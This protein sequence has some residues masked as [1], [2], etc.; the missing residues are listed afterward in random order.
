MSKRAPDGYGY[1]T[2]SE[3]DS[4]SWQGEALVCLVE[5]ICVGPGEEKERK[6]ESA[7]S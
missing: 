7:V 3:T 6:Y 2:D 4:D 5:R 1:R